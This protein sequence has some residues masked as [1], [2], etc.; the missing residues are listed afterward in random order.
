MAA[1][2]FIRAICLAGLLGALAGIS[3]GTVSA[4]GWT[5]GAS[6]GAAQNGAG[7]AFGR[8]GAALSQEA[9]E[10]GGDYGDIMDDVNAVID[11]MDDSTRGVAPASEPTAAPVPSP[12][13]DRSKD[14]TLSTDD[15]QGAAPGPHRRSPVVVELFT[16]EGCAACPPA[17]DLLADLSGRGDVLVLS[18]HVDYWDYLGWSDSF[19]R[20]EFSARQKAYNL[21]R[22]AR[23]LFTPQII[24]GGE[25]AIDMP[26]PADLMSAIRQQRDEGDHV[27]VAYEQEGARR[28]VELTPRG[29]LPSDN[30]VQLIRYLPRRSVEVDSGENSGRLL[31]LRNVVAAAE[32]LAEWDGAAPIRLT[33]TLGAGRSTNLPQDTRH[34]LI[35]QD[36][37]GGMPGEIFA[38]VPLD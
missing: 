35:V 33:V 23:S 31:E 27:T 14:A 32:I 25:M 37:R 29:S 36:M 6:A 28:R 12:T 11:A 13:L 30:A 19:A 7:T 22:G 5:E 10:L 18:W 17:Q 8:A 15:A 38:A 21:S 1:A 4:Q 26:R 20:P 34:A 24:V 16:A 3:V 2:G 9:P